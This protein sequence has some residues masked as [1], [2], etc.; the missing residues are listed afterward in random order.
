MNNVYS[1]K[2]PELCIQYQFA[3]KGK[4]KQTVLIRQKQVRRVLNN[5]NHLHVVY[6]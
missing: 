2:D 5:S 6:T 1:T 3:K 4:Y